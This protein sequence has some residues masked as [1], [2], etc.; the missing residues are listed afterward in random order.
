MNL[1]L[2]QQKNKKMLKNAMYVLFTFVWQ[3]IQET[4]TDFTI[5]ALSKF[6]KRLDDL[7]LRNQNMFFVKLYLHWKDRSDWLTDN[8]NLTP[9]ASSSLTYR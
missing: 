4:T 8:N 7:P 6:K 2:P 1:K 5:T 9:R 3:E